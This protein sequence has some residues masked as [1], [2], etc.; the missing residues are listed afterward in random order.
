MLN[1]PSMTSDE[2]HAFLVINV[3]SFLWAL[4]GL[5]MGLL[6]GAYLWR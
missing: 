6:L 1:R 5:G 4:V 2:A 3:A